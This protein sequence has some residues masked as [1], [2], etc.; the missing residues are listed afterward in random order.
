MPSARL[1]VA[2]LKPQAST[3]TPLSELE[4]EAIDLF[5]SFMKLIGL[6]KSVGEIYGLLFVA[7]AP[8]NAEQITERLQI[9]AGAVSQGLKLLRSLGAV[10]SVYVAGDRRDHFSADLDLSTFASAF[11][12]EELN[13]HLEHAAERI[14]RME[15]LAK[16][17][18][19]EER[20]PAFKRIERLRHWMERGRKMMPWLLK[21]LVN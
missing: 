8:L 5:I 9:S 19:A 1:Q 11:I 12:K 16:D 13:P 17:L 2:E 15:L 3:S 14:K 4:I 18:E 6:P 10:R 20:D 7:G 21:F